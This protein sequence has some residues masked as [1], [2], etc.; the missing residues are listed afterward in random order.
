MR[1][2]VKL[3][4]IR[5]GGSLLALVKSLISFMVNAKTLRVLRSR[6]GGVE[7]CACDMI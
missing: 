7:G 3:A 1:H 6:G 4:A 2:R 5:S